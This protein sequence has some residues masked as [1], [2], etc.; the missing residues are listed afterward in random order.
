M[1]GA[2]A[3]IMLFGATLAERRDRFDVEV[4]ENLWKSL[5]QSAL[6]PA[7]NQPGMRRGIDS[8]DIISLLA[9]SPSPCER[10]S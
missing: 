6:A 9:M 3:S 7:A 10:L 4:G 8:A 5:M 2:R 1:G